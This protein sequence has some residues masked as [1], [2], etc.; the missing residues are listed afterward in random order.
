MAIPA[1]GPPVVQAADPSPTA[2]S[3]RRGAALHRSHASKN[4]H[5]VPGLLRR[6]VWG[7]VIIQDPTTT[8]A[9]AYT[10]PVDERES[11]FRTI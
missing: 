8:V 4:S 11:A 3:M 2:L 5:T 6:W 9:G 7:S 10:P 1:I